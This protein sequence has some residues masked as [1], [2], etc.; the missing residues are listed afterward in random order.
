MKNDITLA[1]HSD[2]TI[3]LSY[4][5]SKNNPLQNNKR[6]DYKADETAYGG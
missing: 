5:Y 6:V 1:A 4:C 3:D 2:D